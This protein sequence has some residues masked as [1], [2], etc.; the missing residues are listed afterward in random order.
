M[1]KYFLS[2]SHNPFNIFNVLNFRRK[3]AKTHPN[4]FDPCG[5][6]VFC[7]EQGAGKTLSAVQY[8]LKVNKTYNNC[9]FCSNVAIDRFRV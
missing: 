1:D 9:V 6:L 5:L 8:C 2:G 7:A 3:F 4:F